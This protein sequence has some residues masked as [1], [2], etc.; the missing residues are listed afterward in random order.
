MQ[1]GRG[2][3][4][5]EEWW[6]V[7]LGW[8][9]GTCPRDL[10]RVRLRPREP[11]EVCEQKGQE[12]TPSLPSCPV[13]REVGAGGHLGLCSLSCP[14]SG[15]ATARLGLGASGGGQGPGGK[16]WGR[17]R[18]WTETGLGRP[19]GD[20]ASGAARSPVPTP[21]GTNPGSQPQ[22]GGRGAGQCLGHFWPLPGGHAG[23]TPPSGAAGKC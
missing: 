8:R 6:E 18:G 14:L 23:L 20:Q 17:Q 21:S 12:S 4:G 7:R 15:P 11:Q 5:A 3:G 16:G 10:L 19:P 13:A 2:V 1:W 9:A 22:S